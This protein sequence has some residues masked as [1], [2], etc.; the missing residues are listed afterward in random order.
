MSR[1]YRKWTPEVFRNYCVIED[2]G[3]WRW[4]GRTYP[5]TYGRIG[6]NGGELCSHRLSWIVH[7]GD[8]PDELWVLHKCDNPACVNPEHLFLGTH[9]DNEDDKISKGRQM[10]GDRHYAAKL[11]SS[12][13]KEIRSVYGRGTGVQLAKKYG[14]SPGMISMIRNNKNWRNVN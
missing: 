8:I 3:C 7:C 4:I 9:R 1:T 2:N 6:Y 14:V 5:N 12:E 10:K 13:V 11:T